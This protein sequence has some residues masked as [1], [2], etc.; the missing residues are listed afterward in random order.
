MKLMHRKC[1]AFLVAALLLLGSG[2]SALA[3]TPLKVFVNGEDVSA[4]VTAAIQEGRT[5]VSLRA[6]SEIL[7][8]TVDYDAKNGTI[9]VTGG[10]LDSPAGEP[11]VP[12]PATEPAAPAA[13]LD[14]TAQAITAAIDAEKARLH[15]ISKFIWDNPELGNAEFKAAELLTGELEK[16]GFKVTRGLKGIKPAADLAPG[17][18]PEYLLDTAFKAVFAGKPGGPTIAVMIEYDALPMGHGCGHNTMATSGLATAIGLSKVMADLPGTLI[19]IGTPNEEGAGPLGGKVWLMNAGHFDGVDVALIVHDG[20]R[21]DT[22]SDWLAIRSTTIKYTGVP[23]HAAA[24]PEKGVSALDAAILFMNGLDA[25]REHVRQDTRMHA[26]I[27][28]GGAAAN[29]V[30]EKADIRIMV[31][32]LDRPYVDQLVERVSKI[33]EGAAMATGAKVDYSW[34]SG[35]SAPINVPA[36]DDVVLEHAVLVGADPAR[37]KPWTA[38]AS[39][40]LGDVGF[41]LPTCNLWFPIAPEGSALHTNEQMAAAGTP[42]AADAAIT[43]GKALAVSAYNLFTHPEKVSAIKAQFNALKTDLMQ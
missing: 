36:L 19:A 12:V 26:I 40:D 15:E 17:E 27:T 21:W 13:E 38:L 14:A 28:N 33:A 3:D 10:E 11:A 43:A 7:G 16:H 41:M 9:Y 24:A 6:L 2:I 4:R 35:L 25:M 32:A 1:L 23:S 30:P 22:G 5:M 39:S 8:F 31:R 20:D 18:N 42:E 34:N 29:I 37:V